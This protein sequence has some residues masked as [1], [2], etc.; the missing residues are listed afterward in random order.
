[1]AVV[2]HNQADGLRRCLASLQASEGRDT[3][4]VIVVENGSTDGSSRVDLDFPDVQWIKLPKNFGLTKALNLGWRA[5]DAQYVLF[6]HADTEV[7]PD[8]IMRLAA[9]LD[10]NQDA[11]AVC[12]LLVDESER[13]APQLG[14]F[15][16]KGQWR[17]AQPSGGAPVAVDYPRGAALMVRVFYIKAIRQIDEH[18][19]QFGA[20]ADLAMQIKRANRKILLVPEAHVRHQGRAS[21]STLEKADL[22]LARA[23]FIAKYQGTGA[24]M[25]ARLGEIFGALAGFRLGELKHLVAG[26]KVDGTR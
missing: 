1:V 2:S 6:L 10:E 14:S 7:A 17:P 18:Y 16:P 8:A 24:G 23:V 25:K 12:P 22:A 13:P 3:F 9:T 11:V 19:G 15:P 20:D 21:Y 4:Q 26:E 5:A